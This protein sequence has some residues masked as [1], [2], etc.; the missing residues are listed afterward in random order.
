MSSWLLLFKIVGSVTFDVDNETVCF[1]FPTVLTN[2]STIHIEYTGILNDQ[3]RGFYRSKYVH[4]DFPD[5]ERYTAVTQ[6][7]VSIHISSYSNV[8]YTYWAYIHSNSSIVA[9]ATMSPSI[10][11]VVM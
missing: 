4:P 6:F 1:E 8:V 5:E 11:I 9:I 10:P 3:M 2:E 7:E